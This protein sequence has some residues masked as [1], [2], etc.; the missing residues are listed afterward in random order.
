[1][2]SQLLL[3]VLNLAMIATSAL[4][5]WRGLMVMTGSESPVVVVLR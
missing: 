3:Q 5:I 4:M 2:L 1:L